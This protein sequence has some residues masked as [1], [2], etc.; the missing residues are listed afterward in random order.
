VNWTTSAA[1]TQGYIWPPNG[2]DVN[3]Y[4]DSTNPYQIQA[5]SNWAGGDFTEWKS[6]G[7]Q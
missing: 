7:P 4:G 5:V 1:P 2:S 6:G 3:G